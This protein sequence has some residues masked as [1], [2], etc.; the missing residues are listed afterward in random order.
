M[1]ANQP[2]RRLVGIDLQ[3][4]EEAEAIVGAV[5]A[6]HPDA[7]VRRSPGLLRIELP[8][9]LEIRRELVEERLRREWDTQELNLSI[10]SFFGEIEEWDED[11][12]IIAWKHLT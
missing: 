5:V 2:R 10:V 8:D 1:S 12:I 4:S 3:G 11:R 9:R 6:L 7:A